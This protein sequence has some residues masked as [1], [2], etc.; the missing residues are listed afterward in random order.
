V[1]L[2]LFPHRSHYPLDTLSTSMVAYAHLDRAYPVNF[3]D[4]SW[5]APSRLTS[6][7]CGSMAPTLVSGEAW[8]RLAVVVILCFRGLL[9]PVRSRKRTNL[10]AGATAKSISVAPPP[11]DFSTREITL[12]KADE[13]RFNFQPANSPFLA[14]FN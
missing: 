5:S 10:V 2:S 6:Q 3:V 14:S 9:A 7:R 11:Y 8:S 4:E 12:T 13:R 1:V